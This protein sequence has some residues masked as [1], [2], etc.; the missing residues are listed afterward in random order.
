MRMKISL[1]EI[2]I[3]IYIIVLFYY[4]FNFFKYTRVFQYLKDPEY[5]RKV[6]RRASPVLKIPSTNLS[7]LSNWFQTTHVKCRILE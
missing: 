3:Y 2:E 6:Y 7:L 1:I 5:T 4:Y